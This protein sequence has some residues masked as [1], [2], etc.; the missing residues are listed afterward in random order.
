ME[1]EVLYRFFEGN[2]TEDEIREVR[3]WVESSAEN[4]KEFFSHFDLQR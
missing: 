3:A 4:K 2:C 1:K